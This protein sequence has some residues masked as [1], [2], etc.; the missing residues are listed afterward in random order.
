TSSAVGGFLSRAGEAG[1][2]LY[3]ALV[4]PLIDPFTSNEEFQRTPWEENIPGVRL[5]KGAY[6]GG[7]RVG[8]QGAQQA[9]EALHALRYDPVGAALKGA[10]AATSFASLAHPVLTSTI[11]NINELEAQGRNREAIGGTVFDALAMLAGSRIGREPSPT[12]QL[13]KL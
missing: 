1:K 4:P 7:A 11:G 2:G 3:K 13:N 10:Q 8:E 12:K 6:Q 5:I 9:G